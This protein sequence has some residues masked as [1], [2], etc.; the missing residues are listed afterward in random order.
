MFFFKFLYL[1]QGNYCITWFSCELK[2]YKFFDF[3]K[4]WTFVDINNIVNVQQIKNQK[5]D[6]GPCFSI[7]ITP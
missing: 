5:L 6:E 1:A 3:N 4:L 2:N 7:G